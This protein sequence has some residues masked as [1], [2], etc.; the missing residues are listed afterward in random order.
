MDK[1]TIRYIILLCS[2]CFLLFFLPGCGKK[3]QTTFTIKGKLANLESPY[4]FIATENNDSIFIDTIRANRKG[5]FSYEGTVGHLTMASLFFEGKPWATSIFFDKGWN[6]EITGDVKRPDLIYATGGNINDDL[7][8]VKKENIQLLNTKADLIARIDSA[9]TPEMLQNYSSELKTINF[10]LTNQGRQFIEKNPEKIASV[11]LIQYFFKNDI[12]VEALDEALALL[13]GEAADFSLT[14][15]LKQYS[16]KIKSSQI[17][18]RAP[19]FELKNKDK[20]IRLYD[21]RGKYLLITFSAECKDDSVWTVPPVITD[22]YDQSKDNKLEYLSVVMLCDKPVKQA[23][24]S[25]KWKVFYDTNGWNSDIV[26]AY[27]IVDVPNNVLISPEGV[28]LGRRLS[29]ISLIEQINEL[30][31]T[32]KK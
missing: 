26:K 15:E 12:S 20:D 17:G 9:S 28:I 11:V 16:E 2:G 7:T 4:I 18:A 1:I 13:K 19:A 24:D 8:A 14:T 29:A 5:V 10:E 25:I 21:Y 27:N 31:K 32:D 22:S 30:K 3:G 6:I 23:P